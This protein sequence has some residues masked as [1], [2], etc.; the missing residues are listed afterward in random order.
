[1]QSIHSGTPT[2]PCPHHVFNLGR[3]TISTALTT[4]INASIETAAF[5]NEWKHAEVSALKKKP[6]D[7]PHK[8]NNYRPISLLPFLAKVMEKASNQ[9]LSKHL[10]QH[11]LL[12]TLNLTSTATTVQTGKR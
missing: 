8:L 4:I 12:T 5:L 10:E 1:M 2:D 6:S 9:Q 11:Q 7:D 3:S